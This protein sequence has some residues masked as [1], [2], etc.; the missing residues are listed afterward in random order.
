MVNL[1][2]KRAE[3]LSSDGSNDECDCLYGECRCLDDEFNIEKRLKVLD[4]R[5]SDFLYSK[6]DERRKALVDRL[7]E[8]WKKFKYGSYTYCVLEFAI[9]CYAKD[10]KR[11]NNAI[12]EIEKR[13]DEII[14]ENYFIEYEYFIEDLSVEIDANVKDNK[15]IEIEDYEGPCFFI[16][17][18]YKTD[19]IELEYTVYDYDV[20]DDIIHGEN[21]TF[22]DFRDSLSN[23]VNESIYR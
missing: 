6:L 14:D 21:M 16:L 2:R 17:S 11:L 12:Y 23:F 3:Y 9:A 19:V 10:I 22:D 5:T 4:E 13:E 7:S 8:I 18:N 15:C 1:K 20:E